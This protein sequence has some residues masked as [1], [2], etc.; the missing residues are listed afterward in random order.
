MIENNGSNDSS[1]EG[2]RN[3]DT[4]STG[5]T[6]SILEL[7]RFEVDE[8]VGKIEE[9]LDRIKVG[10]AAHVN[11]SHDTVEE[12]ERIRA[13]LLVELNLFEDK[14]KRLKSPYVISPELKK[15]VEITRMLGKPLLLEGE[16]GTGKTALAFAIGA[17]QE[18]PIIEVRCKS[19]TT[20]QTTLYEIDHVARLKDAHFSSEIP[21]HMKK[22]ADAWIS[23]LEGGGDA[24]E[25]NFLLFMENLQRTSLLLNLDKVS[26]IKNYIRYGGLGEAIMRAA[27]GEKVILLFDEVDKAKREFANDLLGEIDK[28]SFHIPETG[29]TI[30]APKNNII[31]LMT[32]NHER[33][34][35]AAFLRRCV[36]HYLDFPKPDQM[37]EIVEAHFPGM[38]QE[39][40]TGAVRKFYEIREVTGLEKKPSTSEML[41]W[42]QVLIQHG[43]GQIEETI[44]FPQTLLKTKDDLDLVTKKT[45]PT[46]TEERLKAAQMPDAV[47]AA[48]SGEVVVHFKPDAGHWSKSSPDQVIAVHL[49]NNNIPFQ[50]YSSEHPIRVF[51]ITAEGVRR[52]GNL[53]FAFTAGSSAL[54]LLKELD[55]KRMIDI[56]Y[57]VTEE[58]V[59]FKEVFESN[60]LYMHGRDMQ[61]RIVYKTKKGKIVYEIVTGIVLEGPFQ[62]LGF[63]VDQ[64]EA[65]A[66]MGITEREAFFEKFDN[67]STFILEI[68]GINRK[69][70]AEIQR[71]SRMRNSPDNDDDN[72]P[73]TSLQLKSFLQ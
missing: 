62:G 39:L 28:L 19:T 65:L 50:T 36:Y 73:P 30:T 23:H 11:A 17:D 48:L 56:V 7:A 57:V 4:D 42:I 59:K 45:T 1:S 5:A 70:M 64:V 44:P 22:Q 38:S 34:L 66:Q 63:T 52:V 15:I 27:N 49:A 3:L 37:T 60:D 13:I 54:S 2:A 14:V 69:K 67:N 71:I 43:V 29:E 10:A 18:I 21:Q 33:E 61:D 26:K 40:L 53:T 72:E 35:P 9:Y 41:D 12:L 58:P 51:D 16:P 55:K 46:D 25:N 32:S 47:I 68:P 20:A 8:E 6:L 31:F 24:R